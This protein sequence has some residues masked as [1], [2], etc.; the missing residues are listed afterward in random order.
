MVLQ[1]A[2][3]AF[4]SFGRERLGWK[5]QVAGFGGGV[6]ELDL[7]AVGAAPFAEG[8][9]DAEAEALGGPEGPKC[10]HPAP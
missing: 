4:P 10:R 5:M 6:K 2:A 8:E 9:V 3:E 7:A 1:P